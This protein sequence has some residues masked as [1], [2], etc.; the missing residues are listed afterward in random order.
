MKEAR[1]VDDEICY[2]LKYALNVF[3]IFNTR[4]RLYK[5]VYL[6][7]VSQSIE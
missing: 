5:T 2:P 7:R 1:V 4:Y 6:N 3:D